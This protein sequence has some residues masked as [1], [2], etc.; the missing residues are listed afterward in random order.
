MTP[1]PQPAPDDKPLGPPQRVRAGVLEVAFH[2]LGPRGGAPVVLLHGF[3]YDVH[4][5]GEVA[6]RLAAAGLDV[7]VPHLR[8]F[9]GTAFVDAT[10]MRSGQQA[11]LGADLLALIDALGLDRPVV[12][13]YDWGGRAA[14]VA[15]AL[16]PE[17]L[18]GLVS[19]NRYNIQ[20]IPGSARPASPDEEHRRWYQYWLH[21]ERGARGLA[22]DRRAFIRYCWSLWSPT[23]AFDEASFQ[24]SAPAWDHPDFVAVALHSYRHR[25]G[26]VAGDPAHDA[27]EAAL[28]RQPA[29][30]V[31]AVTLDGA[32][33]GVVL[34]STEPPTGR[35]TRLVAHRVVAGAGHNLP[36]EAPEAFAEAVLEVARVAHGRA[37]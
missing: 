27:L 36:Q 29:I 18:G 8:G 28:A 24:R 21:T 26:V 11:A 33:D 7:V 2:R 3:P 17:R 32:D 19:C 9:G 37:V 13:G 10:T 30:P 4:A 1:L 22:E 20:D 35:F 16:W 31:P 12:A 15:A 5:Y 25:Y 6:P 23:W 34:P 14:C